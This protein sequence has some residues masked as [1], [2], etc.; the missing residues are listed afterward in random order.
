MPGPDHFFALEADD[1]AT[2]VD[3]VRST[4]KRMLQGDNPAVDP[5]LYGTSIKRVGDNERYLREFVANQIFTRRA[6]KKGEVITPDDLIILRRGEKE[7]GLDPKYMILFSENT[8]RASC[9]IQKETPV[10]WKTVL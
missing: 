5:V 4:E 1:L 2:M 3:A 6:I 7:K 10:V 8:V 9:D